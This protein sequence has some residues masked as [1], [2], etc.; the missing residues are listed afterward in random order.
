MLLSLINCSAFFMISR[1][2]LILFFLPAFLGTG[3]LG[4]GKNAKKKEAEKPVTPIQAPVISEPELNSIIN[5]KF[6]GNAYQFSNL[7]DAFRHPENVL[8][9]NL[10]N[11]GLTSVPSGINK[12]VNLV[13]LDL[14]D[15]K[16]SAL[17][18][19][20]GSLTKLEEL[21]LSNNS[22]TSIPSE[23]C[24][25]KELKSLII[26]GNQIKSAGSEITCLKKLE[27]LHLQGNGL[28]TLSADIGNLREL[29]FL[30]LHNNELTS[31]PDELVQLTKLQALF[32]Q[33]NE[34]SIFPYFTDRLDYLTYFTFEPQN[35]LELEKSKYRKQLIRESIINQTA[36]ASATVQNTVMTDD[37][38]TESYTT[39]KNL[40]YP[41]DFRPVRSYT[42]G[43]VYR[44]VL[45]KK[46]RNRVRYT[47]ILKYDHAIQKE[48]LKPQPDMERIDKYNLKI[49]RTY[50]KL[51]A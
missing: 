36:S 49:H 18:T 27:R 1:V 48:M 32:V 38:S 33:N 22:F 26:S 29:K 4:Q 37:E 24:N 16:L 44:F 40:T 51:E 14:S 15:N 41:P 20:I 2:I 5:Q 31:L 43:Y 30:Y 6:T 19:E 47:R 12:F 17:G 42:I 8:E 3:L 39:Y 13:S 35:S 23:V 11:Q 46:F 28:K 9:L 21:E 25:L 34:L 10:R 7:E 45:S 50:Q